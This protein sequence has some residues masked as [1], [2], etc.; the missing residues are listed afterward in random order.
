MC[1]VVTGINCA[2]RGCSS[3]PNPTPVGFDLRYKLVWSRSPLGFN[4]RFAGYLT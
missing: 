4:N 3:R 1:P 2:D